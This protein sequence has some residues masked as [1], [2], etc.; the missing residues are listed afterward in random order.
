MPTLALT[1]RGLRSLTATQRTDYWDD[2]MPS[3]GVRVSPQG[4]KAF[5]LMYRV[6]GKQERMTLGSFPAVSLAEARRLARQAMGKVAEGKNP[7]EVT[8]PASETGEELLFRELAEDY[9]ERH[10]RR[11]K[12]TWREDERILKLDLLPSWGE[13][14]AAEVR[15]R[16]VIAMLE[17]IVERG[18]P[19][20]ANR[21][22][23]LIS[24]IYSWAVKADLVEYNPCSS[25]E[26]PSR[27]NKR[28]R[29]LSDPEIVKLWAALDGEEPCIARSM[30]LLLFTAQ[31]TREVRL[32][33]WSSIQGAEWLI[34]AEN[35][36]NGKEHL[37]ALSRQTQRLLAEYRADAEGELIV[38]SPRSPNQPWSRAALSHASRRLCK[39]L[40]FQF[41]PHDLRRTAGTLMASLG[42][43]TKI[44]SVVL[45]HADNSV[46]GI[47]NRYRYWKE[48][49]AALQLLGDHLDG[50]LSVEETG[51]GA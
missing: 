11:K 13:R 17:G 4:H 39:R 36:K 2:A 19:I 48:K 10:A 6:N 31:R 14:P 5:V 41:T 8:V 3:F 29:V 42:V 15:K 23:A 24:R 47:Y 28:D 38:P 18:A 45:N 35:V 27:E 26:R 20:A 40:G 37:V 43:D 46:T 44:I 25:V 9:L 33:K 7:K 22:R 1:D 34:P 49:Q 16:D 32:A 50:I 51:L 12:R 21:T 30:R